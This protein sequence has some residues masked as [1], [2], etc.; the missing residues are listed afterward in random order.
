MKVNKIVLWGW[1]ITLV[2]FLVVP[3]A[4][5]ECE[6][7]GKGQQKK[8]TMVSDSLISLSASNINAMFINLDSLMIIHFHPTVQCS[9]CI[10]VGSF[11]RKGLE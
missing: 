11:A 5:V 1:M 3:F 2:G 7:V 6:S 9:C 8:G 10:N 4:Q